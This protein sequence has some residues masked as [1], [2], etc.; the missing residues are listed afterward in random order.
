MFQTLFGRYRLLALCNVIGL[1]TGAIQKSLG[2]PEAG[3][4]LE[5]AEKPPVDSSSPQDHSAAQASEAGAKQQSAASPAA[6]EQSQQISPTPVKPAQPDTKKTGRMSNNQWCINPRYP[7]LKHNIS[8]ELSLFPETINVLELY[9][10]T[11]ICS[12]TM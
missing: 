10:Y 9:I 1:R 3:Q 4:L 6:V 2:R 5:E 7:E 11:Y 8:S 12:D